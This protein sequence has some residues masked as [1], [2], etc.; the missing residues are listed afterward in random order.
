MTQA[1]ATE[2]GTKILTRSIVGN[3]NPNDI[4]VKYIS[5]FMPTLKKS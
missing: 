1:T 3:P 4:E 5:P 2:N